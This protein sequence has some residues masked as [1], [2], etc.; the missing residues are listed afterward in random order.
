MGS[1]SQV[2]DVKEQRRKSDRERYAHM[3]DEAK[4]EKLKKR[5]EA[6]KKNKSINKTKKYADLKQEQM[7]NNAHQKCKHMQIWGQ[8]NRKLD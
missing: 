7:T 8:N 1:Q 5:R 6:Y 3:I 4:Q 2:M